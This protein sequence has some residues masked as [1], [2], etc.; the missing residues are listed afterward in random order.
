MTTDAERALDALESNQPRKAKYLLRKFLGRESRDDIEE[1]GGH[2]F[3]TKYS[4]L[5][6]KEEHV[7]IVRGCEL[8][9]GRDSWGDTQAVAEEVDCPVSTEAFDLR[10]AARREDSF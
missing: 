8:R 6:D 5:H 3:R 2:L 7:C 9:D 10:F 1:V 4:D